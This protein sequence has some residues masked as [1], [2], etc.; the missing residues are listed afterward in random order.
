MNTPNDKKP[1][2]Y[3]PSSAPFPYFE[4]AGMDEHN[5]QVREYARHTAQTQQNAAMINEIKAINDRLQKQIDDAKKSARTANM[6]SWISI[7]IS[8]V[9]V[10]VSVLFWFFPA[11]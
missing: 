7:G 5:A 4:I 1:K 10:V 9:S 6:R 2:P 8:I 11:G 3:T